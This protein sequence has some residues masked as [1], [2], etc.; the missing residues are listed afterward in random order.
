MSVFGCAVYSKPQRHKRGDWTVMPDM[1][2]DKRVFFVVRWIDSNSYDIMA[3]CDQ[4][5][6]AVAIVAAAKSRS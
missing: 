3:H 4:R 5:W 1:W 6:M 2:A